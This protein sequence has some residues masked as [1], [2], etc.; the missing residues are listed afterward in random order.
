MRTKRIF[1]QTIKELTQLGRDRL[2]LIMAL[3]L[4][5]ILLL[6]FGFGFSLKVNQ[7]DFAIQDLDGTQISREYIATFE[8]TTKFNIV[9]YGPNINVLQLLNQGKIAAGLIIPPKFTRD[10]LRAQRS[11]EAQVLL[12]G[13]DSN[14]A[15]IVRGYANAVT[16]AF[17]ENQRGS[18]VVP[19]SLQS[20]LWY[21]PGLESLKYIGP[22]AVAITVTLFPALLAS[23]AIAKEYEQGTILQVY[24]SSLTSI[25]YLLG[26]VAAFWLV[27]MAEV[28]LVN[29]EAWLVFGLRFA[30]DPT[31]MIISSAIY[32]AC[33]VFWGILLGR[34]TQVQSAAIQA[35]SFTAFLLSL[36]LSGYI[37]P[38]S[39]IP[40]AI[41]WISYLIPARHYI[42][43]TRDAYA[44]GV[45]WLGVWFPVLALALLAS[46]FFFLAWR[47]LESMQ[48]D[49]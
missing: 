47:R 30:G 49:S 6:L 26:K 37:Y 2:S 15:N 29:L 13:T 41:R 27:G 9:A 31:P 11:S 1:A 32:I 12:D 24:A 48:V 43:I 18:N 22:G 42:L 19:V 39:N 23:L 5:L 46:L 36:Q 33:G 16:N 14:T 4:P 3:L 35:V 45:G 25:E 20:R 44:R 28:L 7:I 34:N 40:I 10:F 17:V 38:V 8:R 21:N